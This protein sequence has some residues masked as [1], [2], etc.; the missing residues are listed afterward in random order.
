[1]SWFVIAC[2]VYALCLAPVANTDV[3]AWFRL[4]YWLLVGTPAMIFFWYCLI[5]G[6]DKIGVIH[7]S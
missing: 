2:I 5:R 7:V 1:M 6:F 4:F 3:S